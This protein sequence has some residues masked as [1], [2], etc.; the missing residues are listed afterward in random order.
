MNCNRAIMLVKN[1]YFSYSLKKQI[2]LYLILQ[3]IKKDNANNI[4]NL[5]SDNS[6]ILQKQSANN[7][8]YK[9]F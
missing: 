9:L 8:L 7:F 1:L 3:N 2:F 4:K 6:P 5:Y